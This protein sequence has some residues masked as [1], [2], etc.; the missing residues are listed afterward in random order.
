MLHDAEPDMKKVS[1]AE[2]TTEHVP[3][4]DSTSPTLSTVVHLHRA[5]RDL[6]H[7]RA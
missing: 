1:F 5:V 4:A 7:M 6:H 2:H 3:Y